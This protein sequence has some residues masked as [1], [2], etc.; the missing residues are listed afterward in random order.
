M[1]ITSAHEMLSVGTDLGGT[2]FCG[3]HASGKI[4]KTICGFGFI[5]ENDGYTYLII[6]NFVGKREQMRKHFLEPVPPEYI[7]KK[8]SDT[9]IIFWLNNNCVTKGL[10][11]GIEIKRKAFIIP[12]SDTG[13][14]L[15]RILAPALRVNSKQE[16]EYLLT[17]G[18]EQGWI[19]FKET[20]STIPLTSRSHSPQ[21]FEYVLK[22]GIERMENLW[23]YMRFLQGCPPEPFSYTF[24]SSATE[25]ET[26][27]ILLNDKPYTVVNLSTGNILLPNTPTPSIE[28]SPTS[29]FV[30]S[31]P[32]QIP[33]IEDALQRCKPLSD[34]L[35]SFR[36]IELKGGIESAYWKMRLLRNEYKQFTK[37]YN[38]FQTWTDA[39]Y[40]ELMRRRG[41]PQEE[42]E[43]EAELA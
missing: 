19:Y 13:L 25:G 22:K 28:S 32:P 9:T 7:T 42:A 23:H 14:Y 38:D 41:D 21:P 4:I 33:S 15:P 37:E 6:D 10:I 34:I 8:I 18:N 2:T 35:Y 31:N 40:D 3:R 29:P 1:S 36:T 12:S 20:G 11:Y 39:A 17:Q 24:L 27:V 5:V 16:L 30:I 26:L 43:E